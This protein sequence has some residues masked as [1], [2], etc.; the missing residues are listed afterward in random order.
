MSITKFAGNF[1]AAEYSYGSSGAFPGGLSVGLQG[2]TATGAQ[3]I[4]V[5]FGYTAL[6][7]G[8]TLLP[9]N[10]NAPIT[11]GSGSNI[12][13]VTPSAVSQPTPGVYDSAT[14]TATFSNLHGN[15]DP[16]ASATF[17]LQEA[18]NACGTYGGGTVTVDA[19]WKA[20]GGTSGMIAAA[21]IPSGVSI[22]DNRAGGGSGAVTQSATIT[23]AN[24][25][26]KTLNATPVTL[27]A[28]PGATSAIEIVSVFIEN[29]F[30][31]AAFAAGSQL[32]IVYGAAGVAAATAVAATFLTSPTASQMILTTG[33]L[34]TNLA[35][36]VLN[37]AVVLQAASTEFTTGAGSLIL[38]VNYRVHT[39]L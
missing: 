7:S 14:I 31:T 37:K 38:Q 5:Q 6:R 34:A 28:A 30:L 39:G 16:V 29:V 20:L 19:R 17:G 32:N 4:Q 1:N 27:V 36:A 21:I 15:G 11:I 18:L 13:T 12:E 8:E 24:A 2:N 25:A 33:V 3:S 35:S 22:I 26:V 9:L 10:T 23:V